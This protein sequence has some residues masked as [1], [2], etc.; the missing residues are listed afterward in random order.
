MWARMPIFMLE[1]VAEATLLRMAYPKEFRGVPYITEE[2]TDGEMINVPKE[3]TSEMEPEIKGEKVKP[4]VKEKVQEVIEGGVAEE[5]KVF[6]VTQKIGKSGRAYYT[7]ID[8]ESNTYCSFDDKILDCESKIIKTFIKENE[9]NGRTTRII[10]SFEIVG[11]F[12]KEEI[13]F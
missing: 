3:E 1:K 7:V 13:P 10:N 12:E 2:L 4:V 8:N 11:E 5:I 6:S 9:K